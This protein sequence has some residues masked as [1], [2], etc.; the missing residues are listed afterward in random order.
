[1]VAKQI[2]DQRH[3][4]QGYVKLEPTGKKRYMTFFWHDTAREGFN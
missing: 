4:F 2:E 1:M 3:L